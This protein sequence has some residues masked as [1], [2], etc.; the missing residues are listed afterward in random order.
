M[1]NFDDLAQH[2]IGAWNETDAAARPGRCRRAVQR[3]RPL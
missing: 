2:Y 3:G 1:T